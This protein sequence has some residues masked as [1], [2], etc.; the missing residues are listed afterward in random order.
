MLKLGKEHKIRK[1]EHSA[2]TPQPRLAAD[3]RMA[4]ANQ[5]GC[6]CDRVIGAI[7]GCET[8]ATKQEARQ[9]HGLMR[10]VGGMRT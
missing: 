1:K 3:A 2:A 8:F 10:D 6:S 9:L 4:R 7:S 5:K